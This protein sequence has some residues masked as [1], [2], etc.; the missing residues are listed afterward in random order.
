MSEWSRLLFLF[1]LI[2]LTIHHLFLAQDDFDFDNV[3]GVAYEFKLFIDAA[4]EDCF[5]QFVQPNATLYVS[6]Q[7]IRGGDGKAGFAIRHPNGMHVLPY[8]WLSE[9]DYTEISLNGGYYEICVDN[10]FARFSS[11]L[12]SVYIT[13]YKNDEWEQ[14]M[15]EVEELDVNVQN[16]TST[17]D[18]VSSRVNDILRYQQFARGHEARDFSLLL[19]NNRYVQ[20]WSIAQCAVVLLSGCCQVYFVRKL[21]EVKGTT[22][23]AKPRA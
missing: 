13:S 15:K 9:S 6:F 4:K 11:K 14:Y 18:L 8:K 19:A 17:V 22:P 16:F 23:T 3:P 12:V 1:S 10:Q 21:F 2:S 7:V 5:Y 20:L